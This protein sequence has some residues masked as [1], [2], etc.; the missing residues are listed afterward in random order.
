MCQLAIVCVWIMFV[1]N[2]HK[3]ME[4]KILYDFYGVA[5]I[6]GPINKKILYW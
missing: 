3:H 4:D 5:Q 2:E 1:H 6:D